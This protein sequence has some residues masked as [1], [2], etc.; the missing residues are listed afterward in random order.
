MRTD[1]LGA[2]AM[3]GSVGKYAAMIIKA[4]NSV[5]TEPVRCNF[6]PLRLH[7]CSYALVVI[8]G[9][10]FIGQGGR[11]FDSF[12]HWRS[13]LVTRRAPG[14]VRKLYRPYPQWLTL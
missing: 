2:M 7:F 6:V 10:L 4:L 1:P 13:S 11:T 5:I 12:A 3:A 9:A 14:A 8:Y